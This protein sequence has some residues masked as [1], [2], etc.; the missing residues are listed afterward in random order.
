MKKLLLTII[1]I[2][3]FVSQAYGSENVEL[4]DQVLVKSGTYEMLSSFPEMIQAQAAQQSPFS[5]NQEASQKATRDLISSFNEADARSNLL[6]IISNNYTTNELAKI[7][8]WL[9]SP[10]GARFIASELEVASVEGQNNLLRYAATLSS[11][12]PLENRIIIIQEFESKSRLTDITM[13]M[14]K[15]MMT[16]MAKAINAAS[17]NDEKVEEAALLEQ[18]EETYTNMEP[19]LRES[20]W[21]QMLIASHYSY[22]DFSDN[23]IRDYIKFLDSDTGKKY[24]SVGKSAVD[25]FTKIF[26]D[27]ISSMKPMKQKT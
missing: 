4:A 9:N 18:I 2:I 16:G 11:N 3:S 15:S 25:V 12:P 19:I 27:A 26:T 24:V 23:E 14:L 17:P 8:K 6:N 1:F 5:K 10:L 7:L 21:Q 20:I 22:R 13:D